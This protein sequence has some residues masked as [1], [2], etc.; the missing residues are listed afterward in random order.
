[1]IGSQVVHGNGEHVRAHK[2]FA[3]A[4]PSEAPKLPAT[5]EPWNL[6][7]A[8]ILAVENQGSTQFRRI[9]DGPVGAMGRM[10]AARLREYVAQQN[11]MDAPFK[12]IARGR[13]DSAHSHDRCEE[14]APVGGARSLL[15]ASADG[16]RSELL[17]G[18]V[19]SKTTQTTPPERIEIDHIRAR[20][21]KLKKAVH[22]GT[23]ALDSDAHVNGGGERWTRVFVTLSY[24]NVEDW[25]PMHIARFA[26]A[27]RKWF[28]RT[29]RAKFRMQWVLELQKRGA[30]HYHCMI[31]VPA[32]FLFPYPDKQ[33]WWKHGTSN[34]ARVKGGIQRPV[35]YMAKYTSKVTPGQCT[36][37]PKGARMHGCNG[38]TDEGRRWVRW[39]RSPLFAREALGGAADIRKVKGGY[40]DRLTGEFLESPWRVS[41]TPGGRV[42]AWRVDAPIH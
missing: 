38:L 15:R 21:T 39:W 13:F 33:G 27:V 25:E 35:S 8:E 9:M 2:L 7:P 14:M 34:L 42:F 23:H 12:A 3:H 6:T 4:V 22:N 28:K 31:W 40:M 41:I 20:V 11:A 19:T 1:M 16:E 37:I 18:L 24:A 30:V 36:R 10:R 29:V 26:D 32:R 5:P 17:A